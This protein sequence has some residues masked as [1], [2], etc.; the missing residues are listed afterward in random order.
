[1][2]IRFVALFF[3]FKDCDE[4]PTDDISQLCDQWAMYVANLIVAYNNHVIFLLVNIR[5]LIFFA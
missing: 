4:Y 2:W 3:K 1:M 5:E